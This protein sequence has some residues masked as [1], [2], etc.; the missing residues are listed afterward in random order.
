MSDETK[1]DALE[2]VAFAMFTIIITATLLVEA[3]LMPYL[4]RS[5]DFLNAAIMAS[6]FASI[7]LGSGYFLLKSVIRFLQNFY[8]RYKG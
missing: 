7:S 5:S 3:Y 6:I 8:W 1:I 4:L 2:S